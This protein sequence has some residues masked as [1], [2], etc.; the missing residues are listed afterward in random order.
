M[1]KVT[2]KHPDSKAGLYTAVQKY[3]RKENGGGPKILA[4]K[5]I[6]GNGGWFNSARH[7]EGRAGRG[8][9]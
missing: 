6:G 8:I 4:E 3:W 9:Q 5:K 2:S 1:I 7:T